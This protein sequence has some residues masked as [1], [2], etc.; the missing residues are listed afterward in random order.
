MRFAS[1]I[2]AVP[3][4][5]QALAE[6][7]SAVEK[8]LTLGMA[9]LVMLFTTA[10]FEDDLERVVERLSQQFTGAVMIG[11]TAEG[12]IGF[13]R[14]LERVP[15]MS[16]LVGSMPGVV[17]RPFQLRQNRLQL[18]D[19]LADWERVIGVLPET[20]PTIVAFADP[21]RIAVPTFMEQINKWY[22]ETPVVGG[23]AS[24][25]HQ[26]EQN[27]LILNGQIHR[28]GLI[29]ISLT[30]NV[31]VQTVVSQGC[32]PIGRPFI[33]TKGERNFIYQL[34]GKEP[35]KQL[36]DVIATLSAE[37]DQLARQSLFV[38]RVIDERKEAF[39]RG[40]FLIHNILGFDRRSGAISIAGHARVGSTV[41]FHVRDADSADED[42]RTML[43]PF[44]NSNIRGAMLFGCNGRGTHM[45]SQPGHDIGV[46]REILGDVPTAGF[47][48]GGEF[49]PIG[50]RSFIHGFTASIA[51]LRPVETGLAVDE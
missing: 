35:L 24:A 23:I 36:Q 39:S 10:H 27:R 11:C 7:L 49:G 16:L 19:S 9:D 32:R 3:V 22:P 8:R 18:T 12:T 2:S 17:I 14:E 28:E 38:G 21:F 4:A 1:A 6:I 25:G 45:W 33:I 41:Q 37:D 26:P 51:L 48:C 34:G 29:G 40:D 44:R 13:D 50:G 20:K 30:G 15:S 31:Q 43:E 47:F 46:V 5:D 42:L